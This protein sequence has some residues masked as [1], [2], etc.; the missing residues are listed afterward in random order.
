MSSHSFVPVSSQDA[1]VAN[2]N[3]FFLALYLGGT[4]EITKWKKELKKSSWYLIF[5][6]A[7]GT[8]YF[9]QGLLVFVSC[10][11]IFLE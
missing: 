3:I 5:S 11:A 7:F 1:L 4:E 8:Q 2:C 9:L 10:V 6:P